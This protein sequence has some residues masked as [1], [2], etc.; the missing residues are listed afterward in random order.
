MDFGS[1][2]L[3]ESKKY[4]SLVE[5]NRTDVADYSSQRV[6]HGLRPTLDDRCIKNAYHYFQLEL[7]TPCVCVWPSKLQPA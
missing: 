3:I 2:L 6:K 5:V 1:I 4:E 7:K